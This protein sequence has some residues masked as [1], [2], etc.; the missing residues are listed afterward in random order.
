MDEYIANGTK[1][2]WLII[3]EKKQVHM[4]RPG[5]PVQVLDNLQT[6]TGDPELPGF[7][8]DLEPVWRV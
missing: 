5:Q 7:M 3:P 2:G 4:Y 1:L 8:L 6:L